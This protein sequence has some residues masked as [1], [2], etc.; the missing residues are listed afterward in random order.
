MSTPRA[1]PV[2]TE[3]QIVLSEPERRTVPKMERGQ[4]RAPFVEHRAKCI[5]ARAMDAVDLGAAACR[6]FETVTDDVHR[7]MVCGQRMIERG[8]HLIG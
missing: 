7:S 2:G 5:E 1:Q 4:R 8:A 3:R 6:E